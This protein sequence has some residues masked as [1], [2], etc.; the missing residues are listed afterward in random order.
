MYIYIYKNI[1]CSNGS[2]QVATEDGKS[3]SCYMRR[4]RDVGFSLPSGIYHVQ[5]CLG[6][7]PDCF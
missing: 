3:P 1:P 6:F 2:G 4:E 5:I 7:L